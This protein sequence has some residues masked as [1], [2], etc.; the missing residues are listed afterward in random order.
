MKL[1]NKNANSSSYVTQHTTN[2]GFTLIELIVVVGIIA[3]LLAVGVGTIKNIAGSKGV[4]TGVSL[5]QGLF[6]QAR[7]TAKARGT[8]TRIVIYADSTG[9]N[10]D[11]RARYLRYM[12]VATARLELD[13]TGQPVSDPSTGQSKIKE[14]RLSSAGIILPQNTYF[15]AKLS[16]GPTTPNGK[17]IFPGDN[18]GEKDCFI[19]EFNSEGALVEPSGDV[20]F[21][22]QVGQ[23][24]PGAN[25][26]TK[27]P[28]ST[29][30]AGG[31]RIWRNGR[32]SVFRSIK[33]I[34]VFGDLDF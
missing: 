17:C 33:Q 13:S 3:G 6:N 12:G 24:K 9:T 26:P 34:E 7:Q 2:K 27:L 18:T 1:H 29:K 16:G 14:W 19:F 5:A 11:K 32:T 30:D 23:L 28:S 21:V 4:S 8:S 31:F 20:K 22:I 25:V 15:N 10:K